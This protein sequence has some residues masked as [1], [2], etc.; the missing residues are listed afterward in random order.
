[1]KSGENRLPLYAENFKHKL[2]EW[3]HVSLVYDGHEMRHYVDGKLELSD[4]IKFKPMGKGKTSFGVRQNKVYWFKG[5]IGIARFTNK[6]LTP[7][8]FIK[9]DWK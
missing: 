6:A 1:M 7:M 4:K 3:Y 2:G 9:N 5:L 8:E